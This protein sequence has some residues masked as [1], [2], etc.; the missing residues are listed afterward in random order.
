MNKYLDLE[1][2][3]AIQKIARTKIQGGGIWRKNG[4]QLFCIRT[5]ESDDYGF[6]VCELDNHYGDNG[7]LF[8]GVSPD[9]ND[10]LVL[11]GDWEDYLEAGDSLEFVSSLPDFINRI[12]KEYNEDNGFVKQDLLNLR[13]RGD[14]GFLD[15]RPVIRTSDR[16]TY[17]DYPENQMTIDEWFCGVEEEG[18][19]EEGKYRGYTRKEAIDTLADTIYAPWYVSYCGLNDIPLMLEDE[20]IIEYDSKYNRHYLNQ[21]AI[22]KTIG[23]DNTN[24]YDRYENAMSEVVMECRMLEKNGLGLE[25]DLKN[26]ITISDTLIDRMI[27]ENEANNT[28]IT[29]TTHD[30]EEAEYE[31][32]DEDE[33]NE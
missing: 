7:D 4:T 25:E 13:A 6:E 1:I 2:G 21:H 19:D 15:N 31:D 10:N 22:Y 18:L 26:I 17:Y 16:D 23:M 32:E 24:I 28:G 20:E 27:E 11:S 12:S 14:L 9:R 33:D 5:K 3:I 29:I 30:D 8:Y